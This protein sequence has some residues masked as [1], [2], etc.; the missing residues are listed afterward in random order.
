MKG[1]KGVVFRPEKIIAV[2]ENEG[3]IPFQIFVIFGPCEKSSSFCAKS[4]NEFEVFLF[5]GIFEGLLVHY[6]LSI[7]WGSSNIQASELN[8]SQFDVVFPTEFP[9]CPW[10]RRVARIFEKRFRETRCR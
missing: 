3:W 2:F 10:N 5:C 7:S 8:L 6:G 4:L 9:L 1:N